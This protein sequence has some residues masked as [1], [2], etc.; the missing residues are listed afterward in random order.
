[1]FK[2]V[3]PPEMMDIEF[4]RTSFW[5]LLGDMLLRRL[6]YSYRRG[7]L[8]TSQ[9]QA[10]IVL[11]KKRDRDRRQINNWRP[12]SMINVDVKMGTKAIA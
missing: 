4:H 7:E 2:I 8:S 5:S 10:V 9:K 11:I 3:R 1:M 12:I 6:N